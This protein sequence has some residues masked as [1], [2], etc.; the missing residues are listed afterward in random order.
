MNV[1]FSDITICD[2]KILPMKVELSIRRKIQTENLIGAKKAKIFDRQNASYSLSLDVERTHKNERQAQIFL[3]EHAFLLDS[4]G[5]SLLI[6]ES[7]SNPFEASKSLTLQNT[8]MTKLDASL[9]GIKT[10]HRYEFTS[11]NPIL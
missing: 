10:L 5:A 1:K 4:K 6:L 7:E 9:D 3:H 2:A 8:I 11:D